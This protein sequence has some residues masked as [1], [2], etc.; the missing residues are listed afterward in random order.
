MGFLKRM[1]QKLKKDDSSAVLV[2][3]DEA[4]FDE[5]ADEKQ[6]KVGHDVLDHCEQIINAAKELEDEKKEY[7]VVTNYLT[8]I[9]LLSDLSEEQMAPIR[10][11]AENILRLNDARDTY[12]NTSKKISDAQFSMIEQL[13]TQMPDIIR[14]M[15][16]NETYQA[17]VKRDMTYL[18]GEKMQWMLLRNEKMHE[19]Y[20]L[21]LAAYIVFSV[22]FLIM[23]LLFVLDTGF[24]IDVTWGW[25]LTAF[26]AAGGGFF[27]FHKYQNAILEINRSQVNANHAITLLN[28]TKI[29][30]VN[31][32]N[33]VDYANEKYHV[34]DARELEYM[35]EEYL[36]AIRQR[37]RYLR[38]NDDLAYFNTKLVRLLKELH[39]YDSRV[40]I[41]QPRALLSSGEMS[42]TK[43]NL[44]VRRQKLRARIQ[45]NSNVVKEERTQIDRLMKL[46]PEY[47]D[48]I[49]GII[50]SVDKLSTDVME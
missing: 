27:V 12:L 15:Q 7:Q 10:E 48:E 21:R 17:T 14:K 22:F 2:T 24:E 42:E 33:A 29:K 43:H 18:E 16:T 50:E 23:I 30:Y 35:W 4:L 5:G 13:E 36:E 32:T 45:Y 8:D 41:D 34:K 49:R 39:L 28:K 47:E 40:W 44:L 19:K 1:L 37:D 20:V 38:N 11:V 6:H 9:E 25:L 46:H 3:D 26:A 31:I